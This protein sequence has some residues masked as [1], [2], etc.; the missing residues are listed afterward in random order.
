MLTG[1]EKL[2]IQFGLTMQEKISI[3]SKGKKITQIKFYYTPPPR[4]RLRLHAAGVVV[5]EA[6]ITG[7]NHSLVSGFIS[8]SNHEK[9]D[10]PN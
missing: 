7:G 10:E 9:T 6:E 3:N 5:L 2:K 1:L 4:K 8:Q